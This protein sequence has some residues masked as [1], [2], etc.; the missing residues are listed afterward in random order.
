MKKVF[1]QKYFAAI[2]RETKY[3]H[4]SFRLPEM[5]GRVVLENKMA[6]FKILNK[7]ILCNISFYTPWMLRGNTILLH[8]ISL[9]GIISRNYFSLASW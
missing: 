2:H 3:C 8:S 6:W 9:L 4:A 7:N 5:P 1:N